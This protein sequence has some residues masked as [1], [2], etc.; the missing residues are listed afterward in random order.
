MRSALLASVSLLALASS[1]G[2]AWASGATYSITPPSDVTLP[3][4]AVGTTATTYKVA[5]N[6]AV[7]QSPAAG[8]SGSDIVRNVNVLPWPLTVTLVCIDP[9]KKCDNQYSVTLANATSNAALYSQSYNISCGSMMTSCSTT[10]LTS[11]QTFTFGFLQSNWA[12][13][14][15]ATF[16]I[17][18][19]NYIIPSNITAPQT[20]TATVTINFNEATE[21]APAASFRTKLPI[22]SAMGLSKGADIQFGGIGVVAAG[23]SL[24]LSPNGTVTPGVGVQTVPAATPAASA[25]KFY[26]TA[27]SGSS[28][29]VNIGAS[30]LGSA[31]SYLTLSGGTATITAT[32]FTTSPG[33][34]LGTGGAQ[35]YSLGA[36]LNI[37]AAAPQGRYIGTFTVTASYD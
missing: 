21:V 31:S 23:G 24:T 18:T 10:S 7:S 26:V 1:G 15:T 12:S 30:T 5:S 22:L 25:G 16:V 29:H 35:T 32:S 17:N 27:A 33:L 13:P 6:G 34:T 2:L 9:S 4:V 37:P 14:A 11:G 19:V 36:T 3:T 8:G 28:Y 20:S